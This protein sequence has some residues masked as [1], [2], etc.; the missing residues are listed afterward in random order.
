M[1][2]GADI[3]AFLPVNTDTPGSNGRSR[4][5]PATKN[6]TSVRPSAENA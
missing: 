4:R 2:P 1:G 3:A 5:Q 6:E